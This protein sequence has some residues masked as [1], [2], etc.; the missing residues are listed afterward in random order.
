MNKF[1][2]SLFVAGA[3]VTGVFASAKEKNVENVVPVKATAVQG[4]AKDSDGTVC[5]GELL[6]VVISDGDRAV[7]IEIIE[8][9]CVE[10]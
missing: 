9:I 7:I 10:F 4:D 8:V 1:I 3:M 5:V 6:R 2:K